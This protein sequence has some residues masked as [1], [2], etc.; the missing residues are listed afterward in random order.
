MPL[1]VDSI[2]NLEK[3]IDKLADLAVKLKE[4]NKQLLLKNKELS[5]Q[6]KSINGKSTENGSRNQESTA[7][8]KAISGISSA[9][10]EDVRRR[11]QSALM[12]LNHLRKAV[13]EAD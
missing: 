4:E 8:A 1:H 7:N 10:N 5:N 11:I 3:Q 12:K 6:I 13:M 2:D 9:N